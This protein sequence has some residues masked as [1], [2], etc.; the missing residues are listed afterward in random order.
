M[1]PSWVLCTAQVRAGLTRKTASLQIPYLLNISHE[2]T[3]WADSF[4]PSPIATFTV[5]R[6]L[7]HCFASLLSGQ[8]IDTSEPLPGFENGMRAGM[9][10]TDMVRCR[11]V[12]EQT[13][14]VVVDIMTRGEPDD[15]A[16]YQ[17]VTESESAAEQSVRGTGWIDNDDD[18]V[19]MDVARVYENTIVKLGEALGDGAGW[20][21]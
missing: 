12:V 4:A 2:F 17:D 7:D 18:E 21:S 19:H 9:S 8:D 11:S 5:L 6:K 1:A 13:R 14:L 10:R 16:E 20:D 3:T 15:E